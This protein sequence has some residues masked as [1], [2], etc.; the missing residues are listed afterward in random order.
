MDVRRW[1]ILQWFIVSIA[2]LTLNTVVS[3][4]GVL[5]VKPTV[6]T[7]CPH[8]PC[9]ILQHYAQRWP[10]YLTSNTVVQFLPGEHVLEGDWNGLFIESVSNLTLIGSNSTIT[11]SLPLSLPT[12]TSRISCT[13]G[14]SYFV[15]SNVTKLFIARLVFSKCGG[16]TLNLKLSTT[17][18]IPYKV[19]FTLLLYEVSNLVLD[20][21]TIKNSTG[22]GLWGYNLLGK[23]LIYRS[24]FLL[25]SAAAAP[26]AGNI[27]LLYKN[28]SGNSLVNITSS[29]IM[30]GNTNATR[31]PCVGGLMLGLN[32]SRYRVD[33]H[34]HNTTMK[35][36]VGGNMYLC[37]HNSGSKTVTISDSHFEGGYTLHGGGGISIYSQM[38]D[39]NASQRVH[40][41]ITNS[42]FVGNYAELD[43]GAVKFAVSSS[44]YDHIE[45]HINGSTFHNNTA[46]MY[47]GH[48]LL[49]QSDSPLKGNMSI[50]INKCHFEN[51]TAFDGGG[52]AVVSSY[53]AF[54]C[55]Q[56]S[57]VDIIDTE[58]VGNHADKD[59]GAVM[60]APSCSL[61]CVFTVM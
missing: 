38:T 43:G 52:L 35:R 46:Q 14:K 47:G 22:T 41:S 53:K 9:H 34:I 59:G 61:Y 50:T 51:G 19:N 28:C 25:N 42:E 45:M 23:S 6:A 13:G 27:L 4:S 7:S 8:Q 18:I 26:C 5:F 16:G 48:I 24:A 57:H 56:S 37:L 10:F 20:T 1:L 17:L 12:A 36:N 49:S 11:D 60:A 39:Y 55:V 32:Q 33:V 3:A 30:S 31:Y 29:W 15:F 44:P 2:T 54:Q 40:V 58:F 21:V